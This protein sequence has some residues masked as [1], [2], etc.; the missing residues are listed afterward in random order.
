MSNDLSTERFIINGK[1]YLIKDEI[2][3]CKGC[4]FNGRGSR[5]CCDVNDETQIHC[6]TIGF[7]YVEDTP[8]AIMKYLELKLN[9]E[10][11]KEDD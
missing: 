11:E 6:G 9:E 2:Y 5:T 4:A 3:I 10:E 1:D 7:I 8:E